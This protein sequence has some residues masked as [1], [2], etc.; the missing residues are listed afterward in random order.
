MQSPNT[1]R[2][3]KL[4]TALIETFG[5]SPW[6][7]TVVAVFLF[8]LGAAAVLWVVLSAPPRTI[9]ISS[10]P[11]DSTFQRRAEDYQKELQEK[12]DIALKILPSQGSLENL[13]R[14]LAPGSGVDL[15]F[16]QGGLVG[17][18][19][20]PGLVSLG[21]ISYQPLWIFY[22]AAQP[23]KLLS[24]L[25]GKRIGIG[26]RGSG[27]QPLARAIL[28][29]N[30]ITG[31]PTTLVE[32]DSSDAA[33]ALLAG[34][35][36]A[37]FLMGDSA[38]RDTLRGLLHAPGVQIYDFVQAD[39]YMRRLSYL[40]RIVVPRGGIDLPHD[41]PARDI[42]VVG[43]A[44]EVVARRGLNSAVSDLLVAVMQ[45]VHGKAG[46]TA[47]KGEFP[48]PLDGEFALSPDALRYYK[49]GRSITYTLVSSFWLANLI[50]RLLV[51]IVPIFLVLIPA[52]RLLPLVYRWSIQLRIFR[53]YR[54]L[55]KVEREAGAT[56]TGSEASE[57]LR[58]LD[59]IEREVDALKVPA[60]FA[61]QFYDLRSHV[62]FVRSRLKTA[63]GS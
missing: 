6:L 60:S 48:A 53:H 37:V 30:E 19:P 47:K 39:A 35:L 33:K 18:K 61:N 34:Q 52:V 38:P 55:L 57:L 24:E 43:P 5:F 12:G 32:D 26:A 16:V 21:S 44:V 63:A 41:L 17:D 62:A 40:H 10:G 2:R 9:T 1:L 45:D 56:L 11:A 20:P 58:R 4:V 50:N 59:A 28:E 8:V 36:D 27:V 23:V 7:A 31:A 49:S 14:L 51:A 25:A 46:F 15:A 42:T 22:R 3:S 13:Q 29:L 54:P